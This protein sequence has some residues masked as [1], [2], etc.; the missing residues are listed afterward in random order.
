MAT[1]PGVSRI[2]RV[3]QSRPEWPGNRKHHPQSAR[4]QR[5]RAA[6]SSQM[7][8]VL[9]R[10][11][12]TYASGRLRLTFLHGVVLMTEAVDVLHAIEQLVS[13]ARTGPGADPEALKEANAI[14]FRMRLENGASGYKAEKLVVVWDGFEPWL[15]VRKWVAYGDDPKVFS[16]HL[17]SDIEHLR[18]ALA[19]GSGG[20]D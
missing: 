7:S 14:L 20:Q 10:A 4:R 17:L 18:K 12:A 1:P 2:V 5:P 6:R 8:G 15:S 11:G 19:R 9:Q 16:G 3:T 13:L